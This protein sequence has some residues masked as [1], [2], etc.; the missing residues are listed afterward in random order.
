MAAAKSGIVAFRVTAALMAQIDGVRRALDG[1]QPA[2]APHTRT[3]AIHALIREALGRR[4]A[5]RTGK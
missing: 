3:D 5:R 4:K 2:M 1:E